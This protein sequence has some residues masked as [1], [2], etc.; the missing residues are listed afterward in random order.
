MIWLVSIF[1]AN[2]PSYCGAS[3][4]NVAVELLLV[5]PHDAVNFSSFPLLI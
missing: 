1:L 4:H 5:V 3:S 2:F